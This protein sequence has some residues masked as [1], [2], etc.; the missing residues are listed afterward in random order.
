M[1]SNSHSMESC[2]SSLGFI[3]ACG[4]GVAILAC[5]WA[6]KRSRVAKLTT[7]LGRWNGRV[8][9]GAFSSL[10]I[11]I[12][13]EGVP[14]EITFLSAGTRR[15][16]TKVRFRWTASRR[17]RVAPDS[18]MGAVRQIP[19]CKDLKLGDRAFDAA[20]WIQGSDAAWTRDVLSN[21]VR[22]AL[23]SLH[24]SF[25]WMGQ[26][27]GI[28]LDAGPEGLTLEYPNLV[29]DDQDALRRLIEAAI[30][31]LQSVRAAGPESEA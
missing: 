11:E 5:A 20:Y 26:G 29:V 23:M 16:W 12:S 1:L 10:R 14:G 31:V 21:P 24:E 19:G 25:S 28:K 3:V 9:A 8:K 18:L 27:V 2:F 7:L 13:V 17:L 30:L 15:S 6:Q 4:F 22:Q